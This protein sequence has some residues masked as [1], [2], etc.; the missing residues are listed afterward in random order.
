MAYS[1]QRRVNRLI[2]QENQHPPRLCPCLRDRVFC[3]AKANKASW[4]R[5]SI[6]CTIANSVSKLCVHVGVALRNRSCRSR[7]LAGS[8][9][10]LRVPAAI[11][12]SFT[13]R[14]L[15]HLVTQ[16]P[17]S[18]RW[19]P[20]RNLLAGR[21]QQRRRHKGCRGDIYRSRWNQAG[22]VS[23]RNQGTSGRQRRLD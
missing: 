4:C 17:A 20:D 8:R 7:G 1:P 2:T 22:S 6:P 5:R 3:A 11:T 21:G 15:Q 12:G 13:A 23:A 14:P 18:Q 10:N 19:F 16:A 9:T